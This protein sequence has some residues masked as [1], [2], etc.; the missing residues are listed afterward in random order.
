MPDINIGQI[1]EALNNKADRDLSNISSTS[2]FRRLIEVYSNGTNW[3]KVFAEYNPTTGDLIGKWCEQGGQANSSSS[4]VTF[5]KAFANTNYY[6]TAHTITGDLGATWHSIIG[7]KAT[8][9]FGIASGQYNSNPQSL[10]YNASWEA[11][12]YIA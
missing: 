12:G 4:S 5:L 9:G 6:I 3:Y 11:K 7:T 10:Q 8:T 1:S 2:S